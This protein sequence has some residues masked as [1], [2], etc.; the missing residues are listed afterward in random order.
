MEVAPLA[1]PT[2][3][4]AQ[5][6][7]AG[8][9]RYPRH[10]PVGPGSDLTIGPSQSVHPAPA[11]GVMQMAPMQSPTRTCPKVRKR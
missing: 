5:T 3:G 6:E 8:H 9:D 1:G 7:L 10:A 2:N 4:A 11:T